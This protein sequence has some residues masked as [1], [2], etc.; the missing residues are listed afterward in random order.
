MPRAQG[1]GKPK[2][3][4]REDAAREA[5]ARA[6]ELRA[7]IARADRLY[8]EEARPEL[9][10]AEYDAHFAELRRLEEK[11]PDLVTPDSP[12]QKLGDR[13]SAGRAA[14]G[15][16]THAIPLL[17]LDNTYAPEELAA[18][19]ERVRKAVSH[20]VYAVEPKIDGVAVALTYRDGKLVTAATRGDGVTGE[21]VLGNVRRIPSLP[22]RIEI[23]P[24]L[25]AGELHL[26]GEVYIA[27]SR[28]A[29]LVEEMTAAGETP[30]ANPRNTAAGALKLQDPDESS[31]RGL[32]VFIHSVANLEGR[33]LETM[34]RLAA[35]GLPVVPH[36]RKFAGIDALLAALPGYES[37]RHGYPFDT[38]GLV[39]KLD[40][41]RARA[42]LGERS[43]SPRWAIAYKF[44]PEIGESVLRAIEVQVGRTGS[45]T[46]VAK[47]DPIPLSGTTVSSASLHNEDEVRRLDARVG[48]TVRVQKAGEIIPQVVGVIPARRRGSPFAMPDRC[49][50]C[51]GPVEREEGKI[52]LRCT[53]GSCPATLRAR[54]LHYGSRN[55]ME[56]EGLGESTVDALLAAGLIRDL[57]DLYV[58]TADALAAL[59]RFGEKSASNLAAA[60]H[61]SRNRPLERFLVALGI[62]GIGEATARDLA[63]HFR[64]LDA[65]RAAD[66]EALC[67][68]RDMGETLALGVVR[69]FADPA[70]A[71]VIERL[72]GERL[73]AFEERVAAEPAGPR[74]L[75]GLTVVVTG[76][77]PGLDRR[78][79]EETVR[80][81]GGTSV[82]SV[83][84][85]TGLLVVGD[86]PGSKYDKAVALGIPILSADDFVRLAAGEPVPIPGP[87]PGGAGDP[88]R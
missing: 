37:D 76:A 63:R 70:L 78:A 55:A 17:S 14:D 21:D 47:F 58:L 23:V 57:A 7:I 48:D 68:V 43:R 8:Y 50:A 24:G 40:D 11:H 49:P 65:V 41:A 81:L 28:F 31:R 74:P 75:D 16:V 46:P 34:D 10:D 71:S 61:A 62:P 52:K 3:A 77:V 30:F 26:R 44:A 51:G 86:S 13:V 53:S 32:D 56:I 5:A 35:L 60:I 85:K 20:P 6:A 36:R 79:V 59:P 83:S 38:D 39:V 54:I 22:R 19:D 84:K 45:L 72:R 27:R 67:A 29:E 2:R 88:G 12:T 82:G 33:Y 66:V 80:R 18:F 87:G 15:T 73:A 64:T 1:E 4:S 42:E 9:T 25:T 69:F